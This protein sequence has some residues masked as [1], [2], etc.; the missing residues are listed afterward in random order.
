MITRFEK[1]FKENINLDD[2]ITNIK[3]EQ[4][5][6]IDKIK[7]ELSIITYKKQN[8]PKPIRIIQIDGYFNKKDFKNVNLIYRTYL[9]IS[10]S[11]GD[12]IKGKLSV[13]NDEKNINININN[14]LIYDLDNDNFDN[15]VLVEKIVNKYKDHLLKKYKILR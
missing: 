4:S 7:N 15:D 3:N 5:E 12:K 2:I 9:V 10:M 14:E 8:N 6:H 13:Y 11:N 1:L